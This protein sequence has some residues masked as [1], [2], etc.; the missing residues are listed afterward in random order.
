MRTT[1]TISTTFS[2]AVMAALVL[3]AAA[4]VSVAAAADVTTTSGVANTNCLHLTA[5]IWKETIGNVEEHPYVEDAIQI[6]SQEVDTVSFSINQLWMD[7]GT[8]M[9]AVHYRDVLLGGGGEGEEVCNMNAPTDGDGLVEFEF[10]QEYT[11]QCVHGYAEVGVYLYVG[12]DDTFNVEECE[13]CSAPDNNYVGYYIAVP[14]VPVC[15]PVTPDCFS[16]PTVSLADI[17]HENSCLYDETPIMTETTGLKENSVEFTIKNTWPTDAVSALSIHYINTDGDVVCDTFTDMDGFESTSAIEALCVNGLAEVGIQI[18][19]TGIDFISSIKPEECDVPNGM[20]HCSYEFVVPCMEGDVC[21]GDTPSPTSA[22]SLVIEE[23]VVPLCVENSLPVITEIAGN[24]SVYTGVEDF[25]IPPVSII[26]QNVD[27]VKVKITQVFNPDGIPMMAVGYRDE[28]NDFTCDMETPQVDYNFEME[29]TAQCTMGYAEIA[30][31]LYVGS[32]DDFDAEQCEACTLPNQ[33]DYVAF[34]LV[35][36]CTP[37]CKPETPDCLDGPMVVLAD[38]EHEAVC[39]YD[40]MPIM[41]NEQS[42]NIDN[43][44]FYIENTWSDDSDISSVSVS[45]MEPKTGELECKTFEDVGGATFI[46]SGF[47]QALCVNGIATVIVEAHSGGIDYKASHLSP[48]ACSPINS[49]TIGTCAYEMVIPCDPMIEC[50]ATAGPTKTPTMLP[51]SSPTG[52]PTASPSSTP[53]ASPSASPSSGPTTSPSSSPTASPSSGP[54]TSPSKSPT[55]TPSSSPTSAP[56]GSPSEAP[57]G[58]YF[59][60]SAP[61]DS[62]TK[63][64]APSASPSAS[65]SANPTAGPTSSPK[66]FSKC[67][68]FVGSYRRTNIITI[69][70]SK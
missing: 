37:V 36:P 15:D 33:E 43:V 61:S 17:E 2:K 62:P 60:S 46:K 24:D 44:E 38:V 4:S 48:N 68:S 22:P 53:T 21:T 25:E 5:P 66:C 40:D 1:T 29:V 32:A 11:A 12:P 50:G 6:T 39:L 7:T 34:Y 58:S 54:T 59:P 31:Y 14:C 19:S 30:L 35:V 8:P 49:A 56:T 45:Y 41:V 52:S 18:H 26:A 42:M 70:K 47:I 27:D 69:R 20:G 3:F 9:I 28:S 13:A 64:P 65:P 67:L 16:G 63:S 10:T 51:S 55:A 57:S 23:I